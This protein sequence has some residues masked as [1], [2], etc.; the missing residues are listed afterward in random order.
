M[1]ANN[2]IF[3]SRAV[4]MREYG[5]KPAIKT[6]RLGIDIKQVSNLYL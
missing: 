1:R 2:S 6:E 5:Y 3:S 4:L